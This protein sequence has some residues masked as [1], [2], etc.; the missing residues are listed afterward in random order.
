MVIT[1]EVPRSFTSLN[2][3]ILFCSNGPIL[4]VTF[5][6]AAPK[7]ALGADFTDTLILKA[8]TSSTS[9]LPFMAHPPPTVMLA[10]SGGD[11]TDPERIKADVAPGKATFVIGKCKRPDSGEY[12]LSLQ[13]DHGQATLTIKV[14]VLGGCL[15]TNLTFSSLLQ[16]IAQQGAKCVHSPMIKIFT[17]FL[18]SHPCRQAQPTSQPL[19]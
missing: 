8:G 16:L 18:G 5:L 11:I 3:L 10:F 1:Q 7:F 9:E 15:C 4:S 2:I 17:K 14:V 13:N 12:T 19:C 6:A